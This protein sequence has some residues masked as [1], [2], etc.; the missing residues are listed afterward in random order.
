MIARVGNIEIAA[1]VGGDALRKTQARRR[2]RTSRPGKA[3]ALSEYCV[4]SEAGTDS[5][6]ERLIVFEH[7][8]V[9]RV[10]H[11]EIPVAVHRD[12]AGQAQ[13]VSAK[14]RDVG[15]SDAAVA[16]RGPKIRL[17]DL[18]I[19]VLAVDETGGVVPSEDAVIAAV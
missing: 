6:R 8:I 15:N 17:A 14:A 18:D 13:A 9:A 4:R 1:R 2:L 10:R 7:S 5:M 3:A 11:I 16:L 19:G 12:A